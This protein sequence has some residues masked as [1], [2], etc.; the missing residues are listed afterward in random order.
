M[1]GA[2]VRRALRIGQALQRV[3]LLL[4]RIDARE[5][6]V[7]AQL[8]RAGRN[9]VAEQPCHQQ[10]NPFAGSRR[11]PNAYKPSRCQMVVLGPA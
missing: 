10:T 11:A 7:E 1:Q 3:N 6:A 8:R 2:V 5:F 9:A 4:E